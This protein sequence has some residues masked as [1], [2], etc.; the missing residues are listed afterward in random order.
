MGITKNRIIKSHTISVN[1]QKWENWSFNITSL[2]LIEHYLKYG[3][4]N[5]SFFFLCKMTSNRFAGVND[6]MQVNDNKLKQF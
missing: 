2:S 1:K 6:Q 5:L 3:L 4:I